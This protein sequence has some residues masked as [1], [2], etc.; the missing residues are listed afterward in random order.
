M[1]RFI[2][3]ADIVFDVGSDRPFVAERVFKFSVTITP[4]L[5]HDRHFDLCPSFHGAIEGLIDI[6]GR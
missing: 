6:R 4:K 1:L 2:S 3:S 5:I